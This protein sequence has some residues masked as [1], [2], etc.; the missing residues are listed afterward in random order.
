MTKNWWLLKG[1]GVDLNGVQRVMR[2]FLLLVTVVIYYG[3]VVIGVKNASVVVSGH[4]WIENLCFQGFDVMFFTELYKGCVWR[5]DLVTM[6]KQV[7]ISNK[8]GVQPRT[9]G[10]A[11]DDSNLYFVGSTRATQ[12]GVWASSL[13]NPESVRLIATTER[14]GNGLG[15]YKDRLYVSSEGNFLPGNGAVY[16]VDIASGS[17]VPLTTSLW[18]CDGLWIDQTEGLLYV[19]ELFEGFVYVWNLAYR[20]PKLVG[21]LPGLHGSSGQVLDDF[22][23]SQDG[24]S[25]IGCAWTEGAIYK[26]PA[27]NASGAS[28][29]LVVAPGIL[30]HPTSARWNGPSSLFVSEGS[31]LGP[32]SS[33]DRIWRFDF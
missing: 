8:S 33:I 14:D 31:S 26:F 16:E 6:E 20:P 23:L 3:V 9:L 25:I 15:L 29:T 5:L 13:A 32:D 2:G 24:T 21:K 27:Y 4:S 7:W 30:R 12:Y 1:L 28:P 17:V 22:C 19:G 10:L 11:V 18:G